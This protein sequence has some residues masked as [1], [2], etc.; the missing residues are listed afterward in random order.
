MV[1]R[2]TDQELARR[3]KLKRLEELGINPWGEA[4]ERTDTSAT[5]REKANGK[6]N[7]ELEA[8]PIHVTVAGRIMF[9]RKM[10]K[11]SFV[12]IQ[13]KFGK[14]QVYISID[15]V[16][17]ETYNVFKI[18]DIGDIIG[19]TGKLML[20]RTGELTIKAEN[21]KFLTKSLRPLPEKFHGLTDVEERCRHR[22]VDLIV[23]EDAKRVAL[24][25][26]KILRSM[27]N[28]FDNK[29][30]VEVE[31]SVLQPILGGAN[32]RPFITHH[33]TLNKDFYLRIAT[34]LQLKRL[35]VG[36][37]EKVYEFGRLFRNEGMDT[38][39]N[40]EFT[41]V[42]LYEAFGD[43]ESMR[44]LCEGVIRNACQE[45]L[46]TTKINYQGIDIDFGPEFRW[47]SMAELVKEKTGLDFESD[48][49]YEDAVKYAKE[50]GIKVEPHWTSNGY[51]LNALFEEF[52]E[53]DLIQPTFVHGH[54]IEVSPLTKKSA[55]PRFTERFELYINCTE[56][57]NAY[58]ELNDPIDQK[59]R[60]IAQLKAKELGDDEANEM[61]NDFI[62]ALEY[63]MPPCGGIGIG[64]DR[65]CMLLLNEPSIREVI[66]FPCMRDEKPVEKK[67]K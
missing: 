63:G 18:C 49:R 10:G 19:I 53:K 12:S 58:S 48:L 61:D 46:G 59:E 26:P 55:D 57:A 27:Q 67:E 25:R 30:F 39:H 56:Y 34:E 21:F 43:L 31:T 17:E 35:I 7:E 52:C 20:T 14:I 36:G 15:S 5:C 40:P 2:L 38:K 32:A 64:F 1:E 60:F 47:V 51:I 54:P 66:L 42:E 45:V 65:L 16:G 9:L 37:L 6:T 4:F 62:E 13:D 22:Y 23:N 8:N 41:T 11:A 44:K 3:E 24:L 50:H 33:N 28:Y 29:G